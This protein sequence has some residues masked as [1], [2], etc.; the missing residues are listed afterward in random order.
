M[1]D[2]IDVDFDPIFEFISDFVDEVVLE[3]IDVGGEIF[4]KLIP[5]HPTSVITN[6]MIPLLAIIIILLGIRR[7]VF[8]QYYG[9]R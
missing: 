2:Y 7:T 4:W 1:A 6:S 8:R 5:G 3:T 9:G